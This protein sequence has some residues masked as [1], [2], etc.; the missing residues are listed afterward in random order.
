MITRLLEQL[1]SSCPGAEAIRDGGLTLSYAELAQRSLWL[2]RFLQAR[3]NVREGAIIAVSLPNCWEYP[4]AFFA[5]ARLGAILMP[6][7]PQWRAPEIAWFLH[8]F[9]IAAVLT[10]KAAAPLWH[11]AA[12][13]PSS[14]PILQIEDL[15]WFG[16]AASSGFP[17]QTTFESQPALYLV[18]SGSTGRPKVVPRTHLNLLAGRAAVAASLA[19]RPQQRFLGVIPFH[20]A[21]GFANCLFLPLACGATVVIARNAIPAAL[22][23][24]IRRERTGILIGSPVLYQLLAAHIRKPEDLRTVGTFIS[25]GA[26]L[27]PDLA[28][29]WLQRFNEPIRQLYGSS[30]TGTIAIQPPGGSPNPASV[31]AILPTV[32]IRILDPAGAPLPPGQSGE[33]AVSSPAMMTGYVGEPEL[34]RQAFTSGFFRM[35]DIGR[36]AADGELFLEGRTKRWVNSG[37]VKVDPSEVEKVLLELPSV[38]RCWV[39]PGRDHQGFEV[40]T[41]RVSLHAG[42]PPSREEIVRHCRLHLAEYKIP[43]IIEFAG[44]ITP[45]LTGKIAVEWMPK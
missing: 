26:P 24:T 35:G 6:L 44:A 18:T 30:E 12:Q 29:L 21:N 36:L 17:I 14:P 40:L 42:C 20:H 32:T 41:A 15:T 39:G 5:T 7:N 3:L 33:I 31:G 11:G 27:S 8:H 34:N 16:D 45:D 43:R 2:A 10:S 4:V 19:I 37:G 25:S 22:A 28:A 13:G 1:A 38:Q 9:P 23:S